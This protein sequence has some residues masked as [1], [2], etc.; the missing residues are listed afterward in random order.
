MKVLA[1]LKPL[2]AHDNPD[3]TKVVAIE[4][5]DM[6]NSADPWIPAPPPVDHAAQSGLAAEVEAM[7]ANLRDLPRDAMQHRRAG[8]TKNKGRKRDKARA[9]MARESRRQNRGR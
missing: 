5:Q 6:R 1:E 7:T 4:G 8:I 3:P 9:K 2:R